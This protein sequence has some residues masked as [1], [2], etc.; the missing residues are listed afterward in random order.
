MALLAAS[1]RWEAAVLRRA[2]V[3]LAPSAHDAALLTAF[4]PG[5]RVTVRPPFGDELGWVR[6]L[7][8]VLSA[9]EAEAER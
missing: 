6:R 5:S 9:V 1:A 7:A 4:A 8:S 3:V 2:D